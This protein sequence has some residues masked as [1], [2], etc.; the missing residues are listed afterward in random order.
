M[1]RV[2]QLTKEVLALPR[3]ERLALMDEVELSL[4][5]EKDPEW[6][7]ELS[8]RSA[9]FKRGE[10]TGVPAEVVL[11]ELQ[12]KLTELQTPIGS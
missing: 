4:L 6:S 8:R 2:E 7:A 5:N 9:R 11:Q 1:T 12:R 3:E 10:T